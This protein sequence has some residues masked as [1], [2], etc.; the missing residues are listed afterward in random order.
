MFGQGINS[1]WI[2]FTLT[3][4]V[5]H[6]V[7]TNSTTTFCKGVVTSD[8]LV[9]FHFAGLQMAILTTPIALLRCRNPLFLF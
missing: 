7:V 3:R 5:I 8:I 6:L 2:F 4:V 9:K 1:F